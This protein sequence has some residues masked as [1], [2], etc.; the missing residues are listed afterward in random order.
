MKLET[1]FE[2]FDQLAEAPNGVAGMRRFI[3]DMAVRGKL[4]ER[5]SR[6]ESASELLDRIQDAKARLVKGGEIK[7]EDLLPLVDA[8]PYQIPESW[9]WTRLGNT[10][11]IFN[12]N[13]VSESEKNDLSKVT[14]GYPFI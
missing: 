12:G 14:E 3:L 11:R 4:A 8:I 13:S 10:G 9:E 5:D 1:F 7:R 2:K 6:D